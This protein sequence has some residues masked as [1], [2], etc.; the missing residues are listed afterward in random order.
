MEMNK[1]E[2]GDT[3]RVA[4]HFA[5]PSFEYKKGQVIDIL[6]DMCEVHFVEEDITFCI[7]TEECRQEQ[8]QEHPC[9]CGQ[10]LRQVAP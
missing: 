8:P 9:L 7:K 10:L 1:I 2:I 6:G 5:S 4:D 3:V